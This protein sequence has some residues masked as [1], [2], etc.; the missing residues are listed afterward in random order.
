MNRLSTKKRVQVV[1]ALVEGSSINS[2]VRMTGVAKHT[3]L[4]L[5]EDMGCACA[6]YHHR[7]VR[8]LKA[9]R[10]QCDEIWQFV[11][12]KQKNATPEQKAAGWG[13][14]WTWVAL[15][16]DTKLCI[17][18][19]I[20]GR[21]TGWATDFTFDIRERVVGR[22]QITTD[23]HK[24]YLA[25]IEMAFGGDVHYA[26]MHKIYGAS[27]D[28]PEA[29]Y[30]PAKCI[31][32]DMKTVIGSPDYE[33]V[34]TSYVER[35]NLTMRMSMR[36]FTRLTNGFSKK[37]ENHGHA[38]ALHFMHYNFCRVHKTLR[39]TPAMEAGLASEVWTLEDLVNR[40]IAPNAVRQAA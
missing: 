35:Q 27:G 36:R 11:G 8:G 28:S 39:V 9:R 1:A 19:L 10:I 26:Q 6:A 34:S 3:I 37:I 18:Y 33:Y 17:S 20:G 40:L 22:P 30:S 7:H 12:A 14:A 21:D 13:D 32:C 38:V 29:R 23:A 5:V 24:P 2:I 15:D 25:A 16:A 4:K 31:G